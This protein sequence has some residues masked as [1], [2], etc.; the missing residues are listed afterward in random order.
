MMVLVSITKIK[1]ENDVIHTRN[2]DKII[3]FLANL[4][5][6]FSVSNCTVRDAITLLPIVAILQQ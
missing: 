5:P 3:F 6:M 2:H 4:T 1:D